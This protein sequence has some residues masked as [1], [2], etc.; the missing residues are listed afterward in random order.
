MSNTAFLGGIGGCVVAGLTRNAL[1]VAL[2]AAI[3][4]FDPV[5]ADF[6]LTI[7]VVTC[8]FAGGACAV[9]MRRGLLGAGSGFWSSTVGRW[10]IGRLAGSAV[11]LGLVAILSKPAAYAVMYLAMG[12]VHVVGLEAVVSVYRIFVW[13]IW[14]IPFVAAW[15]LRTPAKVFIGKASVPMRRWYRSLRFGAGGSAGF[16]G[17]CEEWANRWRP[18]MIFFGHSLF[19]RHWPIGVRDERMLVTLAGTGGGKSESA[20]N[21]NVLL[22]NGS[23]FVIDPSGQIA[24]VTAEALRVKG[25]EVRIIDQMNVLGLGTARLDPLAELDPKARD[26]VIRLKQLV[27]ALSISSGNGR[28]RFFEQHGKTLCAGAIDYLIRRKDEEFVPE[29]YEKESVDD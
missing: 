23:M 12:L 25:F 9:A 2:K 17:I 5:H 27:E 13:L 7:G 19:D 10:L 11:Y 22:H 28:N 3:T 29:Q 8:I 1:G 21:N 26:Y 4:P 15:F 16:A 24:A 14:G 6:G 20:I 18:G